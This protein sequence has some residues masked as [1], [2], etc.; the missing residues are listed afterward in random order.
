MTTNQLNPNWRHYPSIKQ[1]FINTPLLYD[2]II[3]VNSLRGKFILTIIDEIDP[4]KWQNACAI[5]SKN[6]LDIFIYDDGG[7]LYLLRDCYPLEVLKGVDRL[8]LI[9]CLA[10][11]KLIGMAEDYAGLDIYG[12]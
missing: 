6:W 9:K 10:P 1:M 11:K 12:I 7:Q 4:Y 8:V 5:D 2:D 3:S